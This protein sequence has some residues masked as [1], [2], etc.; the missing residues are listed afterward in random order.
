MKSLKISIVAL[1]FFAFTGSIL[2][3]NNAENEHYYSNSRIGKQ[4][5]PPKPYT[6]ASVVAKSENLT[7]ELQGEVGDNAIAID[8]VKGSFDSNSYDYEYTARINRFHRDMGF[9]YYDD[10]YT[11]LYWYTGDPFFW[12]SNIYWNSP[13]WGGYYHPWYYSGWCLSWGWDGFWGPTYGWGPYWGGYYGWGFGWDYYAWG[14]YYDPYWNNG[15]YHNDFGGRYGSTNHGL[16]TEGGT[17]SGIG[18]RSGNST[19]SPVSGLT[20]RGGVDINSGIGRTPNAG[21]ST[22]SISGVGSRG[23]TAS[24]Q[25]ANNSGSQ[26]FAKP[27]SLNETRATQTSSRTSSNRNGYSSNASSRTA[28]ATGNRSGY[29]RSNTGGGSYRTSTPSG[30]YRNAGTSESRRANTISGGYR[31]SGN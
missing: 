8:S 25:M 16:L 7:I 30:S 18:S 1:L 23:A 10:Y 13:Y 29:N 20:R 15:Y 27:Q 22:G 4:A 2:A 21:R 31:S 6:D 26:R 14:G 28:V 17:A 12:G 11:N 9:N 5:T 3:Q 24:R 19:P